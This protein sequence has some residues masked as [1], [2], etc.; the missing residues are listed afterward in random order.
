MKKAVLYAGF[1]LGI[2]FFAFA[3]QETQRNLVH[4]YK[5]PATK[6]ELTRP[7]DYPADSSPD[8]IRLQVWSGVF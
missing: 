4:A 8:V 6:P 7:P 2:G 5:S 3:R 1:P